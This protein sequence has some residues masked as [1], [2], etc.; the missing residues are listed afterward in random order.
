[1]PTPYPAQIFFDIL[2]TGTEVWMPGTVTVRNLYNGFDVSRVELLSPVPPG[3]IAHFDFQ[4]RS[5]TVGPSVP[6]QWQ[7][8][9]SGSPFGGKTTL[10][11]VSVPF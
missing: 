2:N 6:M 11:N 8:S 5:T 4:V 9:Y 1:M 7:L 3:V 10:V